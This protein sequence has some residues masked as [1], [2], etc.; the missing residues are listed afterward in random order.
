[1]S[2]D[3]AALPHVPAADLAAMIEPSRT[4]LVVIDVQEDFVGPDGAMARIGLDLSSVGP[5]LDRIER[6][7]AAGRAAGATIAFARVVTSAESDSQALRLLN[8]R[9]GRPPQAIAICREDQPGSAYY[10]VAPQPG[11]IETPKRLFNTFHGTRFDEELRARGVDTLVVV[12]FTTDCC[13]ESTCRDAFHRDYSVFVV[14]DATD[15][16]GAELHLGALRGLQKNVALL[17]DTQAV[18]AAWAPG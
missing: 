11:D 4:A 7:I 2:A 15:A 13:V 8:A 18:L 16:Y 5:A 10:R 9:K 3:V 6:L 12:G 1:M 17:A 14:S